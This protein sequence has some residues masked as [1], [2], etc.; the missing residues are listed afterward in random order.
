[1]FY[2]GKTTDLKARALQI[3]LDLRVLGG[4]K[5]DFPRKSTPTTCEVRL[6]LRESAV[7]NPAQQ[8]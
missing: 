2:R 3:D 5:D 4:N 1:M 6:P 8:L 7:N